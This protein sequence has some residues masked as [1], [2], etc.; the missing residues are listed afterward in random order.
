MNYVSENLAKIFI[1]QKHFEKAIQV[2][3]K[4]IL[5]NPEKSS[6]FAEQIENL[7]NLIKNK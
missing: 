3:E 1:G 7:K 5:K 2:Y 6:Y 4:L